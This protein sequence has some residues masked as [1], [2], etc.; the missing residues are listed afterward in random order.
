MKCRS[1]G[2]DIP[3]AFVHAIATNQCAGCGGEIMSEEDKQLLDELS[4]AMERMPNDPQGVAGWLLSNYQFRKIGDAVPV[5]KFHRPGQAKQKEESNF[6][7][8]LERTGSANKVA[9][10]Q[11]K[12]K[13]GKFAA[14]AAAIKKGGADYGDEAG[15]A[16]TSEEDVSDDDI[17]AMREMMKNGQDPFAGGQ[18]GGA[19]SQEE[20][21]SINNEQADTSEEL[22]VSPSKKALM[23]ERLRQNQQSREAISGGRD[24]G[25]GFWRS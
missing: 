15:G 10:T 1:C 16:E 2:A 25:G 3:P 19:L 4:D 20:I 6:G 9:E 24:G 23:M 11:A 17:R 5:E 14:L 7:S 21:M 12:L 8:F 22:N 18:V 13:S